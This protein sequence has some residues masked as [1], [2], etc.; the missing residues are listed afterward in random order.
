MIKAIVNIV[1]VLIVVGNFSVAQVNSGKGNYP[2]PQNRKY[3]YGIKPTNASY[4]DAQSSYNDWKSEFLIPSN[5]TPMLYGVDFDGNNTTVSEGIG[6]G[7][8]LSAYANDSATFN[9]LWRFYKKYSSF[10]LMNWKIDYTGKVIGGGPAT[11]ADEDAAMALVIAYNQWPSTG[12]IN[13]KQDCIN[14]INEIRENEV[15]QG[16][17][18]L[19]PGE[20]GGSSLVNLSYFAPAYYKIFAQVT[21]DTTWLNVADTCYRIISQNSDP[22]TGLVSDWAIGSTG[23]PTNFSGDEFPLDFYYDAVRNPWRLTIDYIWFGDPRALSQCK[24][25]ANFVIGKGGNSKVV[26]GYTLSGND[27]VGNGDGTF[28]GPLALPGMVSSSFQGYLNSA[29][30]VNAISHTENGFYSYFGHSLQSLALFVMTGNFYPLPVP[31]CVKPQLGPDLSLCVSPSYTLNSNMSYTGGRHFIWNTGDTTNTLTVTQKGKYILTVDSADCQ[32]S[33]TIYISGLKI[34]F[35][36][37]E[38][39]SPGSKITLSAG[40]SGTGVKYYWRFGSLTAQPFDSTDEVITVSLPG[41]Y[42]ITADSGGC[43]N[44]DSV[45]IAGQDFILYPNPNNGVFT[46]EP[47]ASG[48]SKISVSIYSVYNGIL[49]T[50]LP[51]QQYT[52]TSFPQKI[53]LNFS[54]IASGMYLARVVADGTV[55]TQKFIIIYQ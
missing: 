40:T 23:Q 41:K 2:F 29:Y 24:K 1:L 17:Y 44:T 5:T 9:G 32:N 20:F 15:E 42:Y 25:M 16:T 11:D 21:G 48:L 7:M 35:N 39:I 49:K 50:I 53:I 8:L 10:G 46:I 30:T 22:K 51:E 37:E 13:Y 54:G 12:A 34:N 52:V 19:K 38:N 6:Y 26:N 47:L 33:D 14:L 4:K 55:Y 28:Q 31:N 43:T 45:I 27:I 3:I 18:I 36:N